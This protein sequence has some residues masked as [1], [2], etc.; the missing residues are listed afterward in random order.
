MIGPNE[1]VQTTLVETDERGQAV[2]LPEGFQLA[3][4]RVR[5]RREGN[6]IILEP[7]APAPIA[8]HPDWPPGFWDELDRLPPISDA[9][10]AAVRAARPGP[11]AWRDLPYDEEPEPD[12]GRGEARPESPAEGTSGG[13]GRT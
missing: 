12:A 10:A 9:F 8:V 11:D 5:I 1:D 7:E 6:R 4:D 13:Q 3:G 2:R